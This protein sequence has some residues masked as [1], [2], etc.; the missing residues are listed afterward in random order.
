MAPGRGKVLLVSGSVGL[1]LGVLYYCLRKR[2]TRRKT[3]I[4]VEDVTIVAAD[5]DKE[6]EVMDGKAIAGQELKSRIQSFEKSTGSKPGLAV[7]L[8]GQRADSQSYVRAKAKVATELGIS[9]FNVT[10]PE[11]VSEGE[12][13]T[14]VA[15]LNADPK[16]H[17]ILV[18][19]PLPKHIDEQR[20]M[21]AIAVE[22]DADGLTAV[23]LGQLS[24]P[25]GQPL[26]TPC[27]PAGC[28]ELLR[29]HHVDLSGKECVILGRSAIVGMPM[30]LLM[31]RANASVKVCHRY[32]KD[33]ALTCSQAD[34]LVAAV[35]QAELVRGD[36]IKEGA[37]ILDVGIN[38]V[39]DTSKTRGYRLTGD[40]HFPSAE[41]KASLITPVPGGVGPMTVAMLMRNTVTLA[42]RAS[43]LVAP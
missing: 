3:L 19:L 5:A 28:M 37:V 2:R 21:D 43:E 20:V 29:R 30:A 10:C 33:L 15:E 8:V 39:D 17:G 22:K 34:I 14:E 9:I 1:A 6:A 12:L 16:V 40:V 35:G 36:W 24:R 23:N 27:T 18:Q 11:S 13:L 38:R 4:P 42:E 31:V 25:S 7:V 26:A 32:T 41:R